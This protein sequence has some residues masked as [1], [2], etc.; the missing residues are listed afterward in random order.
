M[1]ISHAITQASATQSSADQSS[2]SE[3]F[4]LA[5]VKTGRPHIAPLLQ[6]LAGEHDD[7]RAS[8]SRSL[9]LALQTASDLQDELGVGVLHYL[10]LAVQAYVG[11][12]ENGS[13]IQPRGGLAP[14]QAKLAKRLIVEQMETN[15]TTSA[16]A[17]ACKLSR[18]HFTRSFKQTVGIPPHRWLQERRVEKAKQLLAQGHCPLAE[19][20][21][22][23]G[24]SDQAH[25]SR[26]FKVMTRHTPFG[27]RRAAQPASHALS[28]AN[29]EACV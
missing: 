13:P 11:T 22:L 3:D 27:W 15:I 24:F 20:A 10:V 5:T 16:L 19:V 9:Q 29:D 28:T 7:A 25:F 12:S 26:V 4:F 23:C 14:W 1:H 18:G 21:V 8:V 6:K 17:K 2:N